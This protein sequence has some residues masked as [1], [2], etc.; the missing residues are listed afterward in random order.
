[1][2]IIPNE[3]FFNLKLHQGPLRDTFSF[4]MNI[5]WVYC[6]SAW[7]YE[8]IVRAFLFGKDQLGVFPVLPRLDPFPVLIPF[9]VNFMFRQQLIL[10]F[11]TVGANFRKIWPFYDR[12]LHKIEFWPF[13]GH[14]GGG[15]FVPQIKI[16]KLISVL[17]WL[18]LKKKKKVDENL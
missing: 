17:R 4:H 18:F 6:M 3:V 11:F 1:M 10:T 14:F 2:N 12:L 7:V 5:L 16:K 15:W 9:F 8:C 13:S